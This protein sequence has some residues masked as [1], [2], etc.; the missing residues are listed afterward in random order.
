MYVVDFELYRRRISKLFFLLSKFF[1]Y[2]I[3]EEEVC[4]NKIK[5][6]SSN[7]ITCCHQNQRRSSL[8]EIPKI[9]GPLSSSSS[10]KSRTVSTQSSS[11][12]PFDTLIR[13]RKELGPRT[14]TSLLSQNSIGKNDYSPSYSFLSSSSSS[15]SSSKHDESDQNTHSS[16]NSN[17]HLRWTSKQSKS[18]DLNHFDNSISSYRDINHLNSGDHHHQKQYGMRNEVIFSPISSHLSP[19]VITLI[20]PFQFHLINCETNIDTNCA[21]ISPQEEIIAVSNDYWIALYSIQDNSCLGTTQFPNRCRFWTWIN[22]RSIAIVTDS[23]VY[24]WSTEKTFFTSP[25]MIFAIDKK[26]KNN[27]IIDYKIDQEFSCWCALTSLFLQD[28]G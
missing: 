13:R 8:N 19:N 12:S 3:K 21:Q 22:G 26:I 4:W 6:T 11:S 9:L 18:Y 10:D 2:N 14:S 28:D 23:D 27:Q 1:N 24:H 5:M 7:W 25:K 20:N 15:T 16:A 17:F